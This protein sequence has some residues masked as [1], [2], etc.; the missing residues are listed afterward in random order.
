MSGQRVVE[1][2][3]LDMLIE[4]ELL[5]TSEI[6]RKMKMR[7]E[8]TAGFMEALA[9]QGKVKKTKVGRSNIYTPL[10]EAKPGRKIE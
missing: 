3:I 5:S 1:K 4:D 8:V 7:R 10:S 9:D 6:A 2:K